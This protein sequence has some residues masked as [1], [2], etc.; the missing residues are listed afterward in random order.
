MSGVSPNSAASACAMKLKVTHSTRPCAARVRRA[1][2][3]RACFGVSV[4]AA[5]GMRGQRDRRDRVEA[6]QAQHFLDQVALRLDLRAALGRL[7]GDGG[8][9]RLRLFQRDRRG[10]V[11]APGRHGDGDARARRG[12]CTAKPRR[13]SEATASSGGM[14][15]P[16][17]PA[18]RSK[19]SVAVALPGGCGAGLDDFARLAAAQFQDHRRGGLDRVAASARDRCRART[20][21]ARRR[22][23]GAAGR[24]ARRGSDRTARIR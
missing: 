2:A 6:A 10:D 3:V 23:S 9:E 4:A 18:M 19:R 7:R 15:E 22:R 13:S 20:A 24:S 12:C 5:P 21:G 14:S 11:V 17:S 1:S 16:P 8:I